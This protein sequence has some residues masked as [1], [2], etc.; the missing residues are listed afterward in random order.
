MQFAMFIVKTWLYVGRNLDMIETESVE[1]QTNQIM[2]FRRSNFDA[3]AKLLIKALS[4]FS[5]RFNIYASITRRLKSFKKFT[6][7]T[8]INSYFWAAFHE[9]SIIDWLGRMLLQKSQDK[10]HSLIFFHWLCLKKGCVVI[11]T[12]R[13]IQFVQS[14][15]SL[16]FCQNLIHICK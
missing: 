3:D 6:Q 15:I 14:A 11:C 12:F 5:V 10:S 8:L 13:D 1:W 4:G 7:N 9:A 16:H 2:A